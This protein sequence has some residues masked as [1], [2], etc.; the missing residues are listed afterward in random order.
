MI[1]NPECSNQLRRIRWLTGF[2]I[3]GLV[4]SGVTVIPIESEVDWLTNLLGMSSSSSA[5][6]TSALVQWLL[7]VQTALHETNAQ[8][9]FVAYGGDWLAFGHFMIALVFVGAWRDPVHNRWLFD[10]GLIACVLVVPYALVFGALRGIPLWW[11]LIDCSFG[12][13][14]AVPLWLC[15]CDVRQL[16]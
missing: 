8:Y 11:R 13:V 14:G 9:P 6:P 4:L 2:F 12:V 5:P 15:R 7:R 3:V 1:R 10:F 16:D